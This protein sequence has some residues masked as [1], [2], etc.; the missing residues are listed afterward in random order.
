MAVRNLSLTVYKDGR[1]W[2]E[3][4]AS[5]L[6]LQMLSD[7]TSSNTVRTLF[8]F[9]HEDFRHS[10]HI[11]RIKRPRS[12]LEH[13]RTTCNSSLDNKWELLPQAISS[14][15]LPALSSCSQTVKC[16]RPKI[17]LQRPC[18]T[19]GWR[20]IMRGHVGKRHRA[21]PSVDKAKEIVW[22][23]G[24]RRILLCLQKHRMGGNVPCTTKTAVMA[25]AQEN[26]T[27]TESLRWVGCR[28]VRR[29]GDAAKLVRPIIGGC[30]KPNWIQ[31][32][33]GGIW[34]TIRESSQ[35]EY[36]TFIPDRVRLTTNSI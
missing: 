13:Q 16:C 28:D 11:F 15:P 24:M 22:I 25:L 19:G 35:W 10:A 34:G 1:W 6:N 36:D 20:K 32:H 29:P 8:W 5:R 23:C 27:R 30:A 31:D 7:S 33:E 12:K 21:N 2:Y 3:Q 26:S 18:F 9:Q 14:A 4:R 17:Y